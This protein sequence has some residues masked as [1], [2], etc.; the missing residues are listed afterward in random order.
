MKE[1]IIH[2]NLQK[3]VKRYIRYIM[4]FKTSSLIW[5]EGRRQVKM[6]NF[7][8]IPLE[9]NGSMVFKASDEISPE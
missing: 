1:E 5:R 4:S 6:V 3:F 7:S 8:Y 2:T 9:E